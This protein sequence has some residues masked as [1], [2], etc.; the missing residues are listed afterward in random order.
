MSYLNRYMIIMTLLAVAILVLVIPFD[1]AG[2][3]LAT[4]K[5]SLTGPPKSVRAIRQA[6]LNVFVG[7]ITSRAYVL[8]I[9]YN[10]Q[11]KDFTTARW[12]IRKADSVYSSSKMFDQL[13]SIRQLAFEADMQEGR[14]KDAILSHRKFREISDSLALMNSERNVANRE[15]QFDV[16]LALQEDYNKQQMEFLQTKEKIQ[17]SE[18]KQTKIRSYVLLAGSIIMVILLMIGLLAFR[19]KQ[20]NNSL[21]EKQKEAMAHQNQSLKRLVDQQVDLISEKEWLVKEVHHRVKN[22]L[23]IIVKLLNIQSEFLKDGSAVSA[24]RDS[25]NR[26]LAMSFVHQRLYEVGAER[27]IDLSTYVHE[28]VN[29]LKEALVPANPIQVDLNFAPLHIGIAQA[30]PIGLI[31][32]EAITNAIKYAFP[33][34][35]RG[36]ITIDLQKQQDGTYLLRI[37]DNGVG[38]PASFDWDKSKS[39]GFTLMQ[40]MAEQIAA[41]FIVNNFDGVELSIQFIPRQ[42]S[43]QDQEQISVEYYA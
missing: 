16:E 17:K 35:R 24:I 2:P 7:K 1:K 38:M 5:G 14:L 34:G 41:R 18:L 39:L 12:L 10:L 4:D 42:E 32:N 25:Q 40:T 29:Y 22:N 9:K 31:L 15:A 23:Q 26:V 36:M 6:D 19:L 3:K 33:D 28:L 8:L 43:S 21:L 27:Q 11:K 13:T 20:K 37:K 30:V